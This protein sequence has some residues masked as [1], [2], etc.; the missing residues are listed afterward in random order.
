M[1]KQT[2]FKT[3]DELN[4]WHGPNGSDL[5]ELISISWSDSQRVHFVYYREKFNEDFYYKGN[6]ELLLK[7]T[8]KGKTDEAKLILAKYGAEKLVD[9]RGNVRALKH[10]HHAL[11][12]YIAKNN[13]F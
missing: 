13:L 6:K 11:L 7:L 12:D 5:V 8:S 1:I 4:E 3:L 9:L 10:L 2:F